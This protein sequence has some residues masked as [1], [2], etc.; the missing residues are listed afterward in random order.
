M[1]NLDFYREGKFNHIEYG[2]LMEDATWK[3]L[4]PKLPKL[5]VKIDILSPQD[6]V[7]NAVDSRRKMTTNK[8]LG[9]VESIQTVSNYVQLTIPQ[10]LY[11]EPKRRRYPRTIPKGTRLIIGII[12]GDITNVNNIQVLGIMQ[13]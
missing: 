3:I 6:S 12:G 11:P 7:S 5:K 10:H 8:D 1:P 2:T 13:P 9:N 4:D